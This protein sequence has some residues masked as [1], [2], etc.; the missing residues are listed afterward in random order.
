MGGSGGPDEPK[1]EKYD[2][3]GDIAHPSRVYDYVRGGADHFSADREAAEFAFVGGTG[4]DHARSAVVANQAFLMRAV[5]HLAA[6]AGVH[7]FL[8]TGAMVPHAETTH[9]VVQAIEPSARIVYV[10]DDPV[11]LAHAHALTAGTPEGRIAYLDADSRHPEPILAG[12]AATLDLDRPV[13]VLIVTV[14]HHFL[15]D[16]DPYDIVAR[17][18]DGVAPGSYLVISHLTA[19]FNTTEVTEAAR[20]INKLPNFTVSL[21]SY[22]D[23]VRFTDGLE[24]VAPGVVP[25]SE[26][27][28][29]APP[30][31]TAW[32]APYYA[33]IA[34]KP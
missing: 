22:D 19:D 32:P 26:W 2:I 14:L 12:A 16:D 23:V 31:P 3:A 20:R 18:M 29:T 13:A 9:G 30:A 4:F 8:E 25:I 11:V 15:A 5:T 10:N 17:Y 28:P 21:R 1:A 6:E 7:Q 24:V 34:R 33:A 27:R